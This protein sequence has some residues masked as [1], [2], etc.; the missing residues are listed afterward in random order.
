MNK[1]Q[2]NQLIYDLED[3]TSCPMN[4]PI[5]FVQDR[6]TGLLI[7]LTKDNLHLVKEDSKIFTEVTLCLRS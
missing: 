6:S 1:N 7:E 5:I 2:F 3:S 4:N